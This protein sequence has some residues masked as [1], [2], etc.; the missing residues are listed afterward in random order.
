MNKYEELKLKQQKEFNAFPIKFAFTKEQF[1]KAMFELGLTPDDTDKIYRVSDGFIR[2]TDSKAFN[3]MWDR[4]ESE[5]ERA[6]NED[7]DGTG[8]I[9]DMFEYELANH[10][11]G[12]TY[13]LRDTL[14]CL[15]LTLPQIKADKRLRTGL[16]KALKKYY[17]YD[18]AI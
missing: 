11:Y 10:E 1:D 3:E 18:Y 4:F 12:Y 6:M 13:D 17:D 9:Y 8:Y 2:K 5:Q 16:N 15:D 7:K 14:D